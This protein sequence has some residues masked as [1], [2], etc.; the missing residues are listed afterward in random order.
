[1]KYLSETG[2]AYLISRIRRMI[3]AHQVRWRDTGVTEA[4]TGLGGSCL[5]S[6][7]IPG[8]TAVG[9]LTGVYDT[10]DERIINGFLAYSGVSGSYEIYSRATTSDIR[11]YANRATGEA[12]WVLNA[13]LVPA[14]TTVTITA[15]TQLRADFAQT[16][17]S[18][19][20]YV[21]NKPLT[22]GSGNK[23]L[24]A[25]DA[26]S[27]IGN[28]SVSLGYQSQSG[29]LASFSEGG[30]TSAAGDYAHAEGFSTTAT[31]NR[32][33][34][35]GQLTETT[36]QYSHAEGT[37]CK[38]TASAAHA[39]GNETTAS[40]TSSHAE[41]VTTTASASAAHAE[42]KDTVAA[43]AQAHA[44]GNAT[45]A[46][47]Q[48]AHSEGIGTIADSAYQHVQGKYNV[49]D[50]SGTYADIVGNGTGDSNRSN[51]YT[52][53]WSGNGVFAGTVDSAGVALTDGNDVRY[54]LTM[55]SGS[56]LA[57]TDTSSSQTVYLDGNY[58]LS[59]QDKADIAQLVLAG[60]PAAE[61][62][63]W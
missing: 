51:A 14:G 61:G 8:N 37:K 38:A 27:A 31:G 58:T 7:G 1:M 46:L 34:A 54:L 2:L 23:S 22:A 59:A 47:K 30:S 35:E 39:E 10:N 43:H 3:A 5:R 60:L 21:R 44:E 17:S 63:S 25:L 42:G 41:G 13:T 18:M 55:A 57:I 4:V 20:D 12:Y 56:R 36:G 32:S 29:G 11:L 28:R 9:V 49:S 45:Q 24:M 26:T 52:L 50:A 53:D 62:V 19:P 40:G 16:D 48:G 15:D 33:H 6:A